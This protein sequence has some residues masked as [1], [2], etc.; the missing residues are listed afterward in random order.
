MDRLSSSLSARFANMSFL[1][2]CLVVFIH[3]GVTPEHG[4]LTWW[5]AQMF[6]HV[7]ITRVAVP[8]FFL[9]SGFF[10][11]RHLPLTGIWRPAWRDECIKR[12]GSLLVPFLV[13]NLL[14]GLF[15]WGM[16]WCAHR[17]GYMIHLDIPLHPTWRQLISLSGVN[18]CAAPAL[19]HLWYI[20]CLIFFVLLSPLFL[21]A[22]RRMVP[23]V[24]VVLFLLVGTVMSVAP[25]HWQGFLNYGLSLEGAF[26]FLLG[27]FFAA[28]L[29]SF[30][31]IVDRCS[32]NSRK[33]GVVVSGVS[34]FGLRAWA[35]YFGHGVAGYWTGWFGLSCLMFG[36]FLLMPSVLPWQSVRALSFPLYLMHQFVLLVVTGTV[37]VLGYRALA[38]SS[39]LLYFARCALVV[40]GTLM[41]A[42]CVLRVLPGFSHHAFGGR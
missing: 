17:C 15:A 42:K 38:A 37:N 16:A 5:V 25:A 14:Y 3:V 13:W 36:L 28:R 34:F 1:C 10:L 23:W 29:S 33:I 7:G 21:Y 32:Q 6:T 19:P 39:S 30:E 11:M 9:A 12:V 41:L 18:F 31:R 35:V 8:F 4:T 22:V 27:M 24:M 40:L 26:F 2:S 20:R